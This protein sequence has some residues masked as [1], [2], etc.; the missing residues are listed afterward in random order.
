M[1]TD[2]ELALECAVNVY[3]RYAVRQP[4]DDYLSRG[5]FSSLLK[6][7]AEPFL[8]NTV[9][10]RPRRG[11]IGGFTEFLTTLSLV[12]IDAHNRSHKSPG[13]DHGHDH[14]HGHSHRH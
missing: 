12:A 14:G 8:R 7:T 2:L 3:H 13:G 11:G 10:V 6:E 4:M 5:E 1:K 9:P